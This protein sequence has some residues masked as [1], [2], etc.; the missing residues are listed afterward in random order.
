MGRR[1]CYHTF[2]LGADHVGADD[3]RQ[4]A[5]AIAGQVVRTPALRSEVL[6]ALCGAE[7]WLKAENLQHIGAFKA[8]GAL[9]A[10]GRLSEAERSRGIITYSSGNHAQAVALAASRHGISA[11][12]AM[13]EDAPAIKVAAVRALGAH[14]TFAGLTSDDRK[15]KA[16]QMQAE[17]GGVIIEPFGHRD[18]ICGQGTATLELL[19]QAG[20]PLDALLVPVGGG[21]LIAGACLVAAE[22]GVPVY[23]VEPSAC[24]A[25]AA[26]LEAG[27]RVAVQPG[28]TIADGLKPVMVGELNFAIARRHVAGSFRVDDDAIGRALTTLAAHAKVIVE[29]SGAATTAVALAGELT[30]QLRE[31]LGRRPR[32]GAIL[33]GGNLGMNQLAELLAAYPPPARP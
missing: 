6:D 29:P 1:V 23:S 27:E 33:S 13:P 19:E 31:R 15:T 8:R 3:V 22:A 30:R 12:V 14:I 10:V 11:D 2:V 28:P 7:L 26:S 9:Y 16:H 20:E 24:D 4:A 17:S 5:A 25:F 32:I 21:G 18:I